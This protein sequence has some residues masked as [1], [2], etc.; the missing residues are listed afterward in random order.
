MQRDEGYSIDEDDISDE[1]YADCLGRDAFAD[2]TRYL[3]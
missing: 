3:I 2:K 1:D